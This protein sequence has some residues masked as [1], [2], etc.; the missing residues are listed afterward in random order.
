[1]PENRFLASLSPESQNL[2]LSRSTQVSLPLRTPLYRAEET[3][4]YGY[5]M[6]SGIASIVTEMEDGGTA[7][8]GIIGLEGIV[9]ALHLLGPGKVATNSFIQLPGTAL[10]I[11]FS[12]LRNLYRTNE[13]IRDR[14][15]E[16]VQEQIIVTAQIAGALQTAGLIEYRRGEVKIINQENLE[17]AACDC[18]RIIR[19]L[20]SNLYRQDPLA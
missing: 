19:G 18:Y 15:L 12:E 5:F 16:Y 10:R 13:E 4:R 17:A 8:V 1:M 14:T 20:H 2:L 9:G 7:E 3:P 6:T 11:P